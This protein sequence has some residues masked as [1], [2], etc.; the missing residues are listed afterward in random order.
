M[1][2]AAPAPA[3]SPAQAPAPTPAPA[4]APAPTPAPAPAPKGGAPT[5][6]PAPA[7]APAQTPEH[8]WPDDWRTKIAGD[9]A[10]T[11]KRL[12]RYATPKEVAF[13]LASVQERINAGELRSVLPK[14]AKPEQL[15]Q[16]RTENGIPET[17]DKYELKL[18]DGLVIGEED[19]PV[20]NALLATL[21]PKNVN[22]EQASAI[23]DWYYD[24]VGRQTKA[25]QEQDARVA[26]ETEDVLRA[27]WGGDYT[28][29]RNL[30]QGLVDLAPA[31]VRNDLVGA[32]LGNGQ[33]LLSDPNT[34]RWLIGL[35]RE[36]NPPTALVP[37]AGGA[38]VATA[39]EDGIKEIEGWMKAPQGSADWKKY[40]EDPKISGP[41]GRY[42][43]LLQGKEK[44]AA[45][46]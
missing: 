4:P 37:N 35:A 19:K 45:K 18:K 16:Y 13:A 27:E 40:W 11:L 28:L 1:A 38:G 42:Y 8:V 46:G 34:L 26:R 2:D 30:I 43:Q 24:E 31:E 39:I 44:M 22:V 20:I 3:P 14:D 6:A 17:A 23:V 10:K 41:G 9:D 7:P 29:N 12:E 32:R 21:H 15:A 25:R 36:V 5:P 33:P